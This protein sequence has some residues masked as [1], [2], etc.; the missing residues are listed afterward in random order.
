MF[1]G[2]SDNIGFFKKIVSPF[3]KL[4]NYFDKSIYEILNLTL[5]TAI[6]VLSNFVNG[7]NGKYY[8]IAIVILLFIVAWSMRQSH[9]DK[10]KL[11]DNNENLTKVNNKLES[12]KRILTEQ[13]ED[14]KGDFRLLNEHSIESH[15]KIIND[16]VGLN[17]NHRMSIYFETN[18]SFL[19][20]GRYS[21]NPKYKKTHTIQFNIDKGA[22]SKTWEEGYY[23][24]FACPKFGGNQKAKKPYYDYN[25]DIYD[26]PK[27][28]VNKL[29]M[30]SC[31]FIGFSIK[32]S[33][34]SIGVIL[35]E[36][37][38]NDLESKK[39]LI[40]SALDDYQN[41]LARLVRLGK[42]YNHIIHSTL[43]K[44][45]ISPEEELIKEMGEKNV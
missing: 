21:D 39:E 27:T 23:E 37:I 44:N 43:N 4:A 38:E 25:K 9:I 2:Y 8:I 14:I 35:F 42:D 41:V 3:Y 11:S 34:N 31:N 17:T 10:Q 26:Y 32:D 19:I 40:I 29:N 28:K 45:D 5:P 6:A 12:D 13:I 30:K 33:G 36:S 20:L 18:N 15:L 1:F 24:D 16:N 7:E 22:L